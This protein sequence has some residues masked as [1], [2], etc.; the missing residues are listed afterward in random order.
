VIE[1]RTYPVGVLRQLIRLRVALNPRSR[2]A[3][4]HPDRATWQPGWRT[5]TAKHALRTIWADRRRRSAWNG[6]LTEPTDPNIYWHRCGHGWTK[7]RATASLLR[8]IGEV[9]ADGHLRYDPSRE[10]PAEEPTR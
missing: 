3:Y 6:Y 9:Q 10:L 4:G 5:D 8:H 2:H 1:T 7:H